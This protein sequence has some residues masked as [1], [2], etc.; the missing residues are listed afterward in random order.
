[1]RKAAFLILLVVVLGAGTIQAQSIVWNGMLY[2]GLTW[3][4]TD[5]K[6]T[7]PTIAAYNTETGLP[8]QLELYG[9]INRS[10]PYGFFFALVNEYYGNPPGVAY[11]GAFIP[12][13][14]GWLKVLDNKLVI[15]GGKV[16]LGSEFA[17]DGGIAFDVWHGN[18]VI[19]S[20]NYGM[21]L[22]ATYNPIPSL[23]LGAAVYASEPAAKIAWDDT[24]YNFHIRYDWGD[25]ADFMAGVRLNDMAHLRNDDTNETDGY[26]SVRVKALRNLGLAA[27]NFDVF[28]FGM[29][30]KFIQ[31]SGSIGRILTGQLIIYQR[32]VLEIG[33]RIR[34]RFYMGDQADASGYTPDLNFWFW[35]S[36]EFLDGKLRP[37]LDG[38][39]VYG[40][41]PRNEFAYR[42]G[43]ET[44]N[45]HNNKLGG[46]LINPSLDLRLFDNINSSIEVG[47][48]FVKDNSSYAISP[49]VTMDHSV[50]ANYKIR[51]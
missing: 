44:W 50:Y 22:F 21:G 29:G 38:V 8:M 39:Y 4:A 43:R 13:A 31:D 17:A 41:N 9:S 16:D 20:L 15:Y 30:D 26:F 47:Y 14:Y 18:G 40:S 10:G 45:M 46:F 5:Q 6:D 3:R 28:G 24:T 19:T 37:R 23:R 2:S 42:A 34:Q 12:T 48:T 32:D 25:Y 11:V 27:F 1:M 35:A 51:F 7:K 49:L 36:Y 33:A